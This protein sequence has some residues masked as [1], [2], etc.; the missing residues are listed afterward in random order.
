[1]GQGGYGEVWKARHRTLGYPVAIKF[2]PEAKQAI[3]DREA[4]QLSRLKHPHIIPVFE[5]LPEHRAIVMD[6]A[7]GGNLQEWVERHKPARATWLRLLEQVAQ[8]L[9][10][11]HEQ[12]RIHGDVKPENILIQEDETGQP[13][14]YLADFGLA[15]PE[16]DLKRGTPLYLAP[17]QVLRL[18]DPNHP[19]DERADQ[20]ALALV[21]YELLTGR[22]P[23]PT[24]GGDAYALARLRLNQDP[25]PP[26]E[27]EPSLTAFDDPLL[28][29]LRRDPEQRY[30]TCTAFIRELWRAEQQSRKEV[31]ETYRK[32]LEA[33]LRQADLDAA[34]EALE[35]LHRLLQP[36]PEEDQA[37]ARYLEMLTAWEQA[38]SKAQEARRIYPRLQDPRGLFR[39]LGLLS[40]AQRRRNQWNQ[41]AL[42]LLAALPLG[43]LFFYLALL[44]IRHQGP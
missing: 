7:R 12:G 32:D 31:A 17:E 37:R 3:F 23:F 42:G 6:Y 43:L 41:V 14:A 5:V 13:Q 36:L 2:V 40:K 28:Q 21:A 39:T 27:Y 30:P 22:L 33:A 9:D 1:L 16:A 26:G 15:G 20:Y 10:F 29:A 11:L 34:R 44:W 19:V 18:E 24:E 35:R 25:K 38:R 8:A 4:R